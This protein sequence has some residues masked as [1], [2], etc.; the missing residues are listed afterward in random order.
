MGILNGD[1]ILL[2]LFGGPFGFG[3]L[4]FIP[5]FLQKLFFLRLCNFGGENIPGLKN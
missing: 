4:F 5:E 3:R 2:D 1:N